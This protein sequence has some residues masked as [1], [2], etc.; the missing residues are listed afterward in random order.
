MKKINLSFKIISILFILGI[1]S[2]I[3]PCSSDNNSYANFSFSY[4]GNY[5]DFKIEVDGQDMNK[6]E[7]R[8]WLKDN[9]L[10]DRGLILDGK[11]WDIQK[12]LY[13][14]YG[15]DR[16]Y[17]L[18]NALENLNILLNG[19]NIS[20]NNPV[21]DL[22]N[23]D[24]L[25]P[26]RDIF[27]KLGGDTNSNDETRVLFGRIG[28][29]NTA[30]MADTN[31]IWVNDKKSTLTNK[32]KLIDGKM[33]IPSS[34]LTDIFG[35]EVLWDK[36]KKLI[37]IASD[38]GIDLDK[39]I[40]I[41]SSSNGENKEDYIKIEISDNNKIKISGNA[42]SKF[43]YMMLTIQ[44]SNKREIVDKV[45]TING[46]NYTFTCSTGKFKDGSYKINTFISP[47]RY[48]TY[49]SYYYDIPVQCEGGELFFPMS[50]VYKN[51]YVYRLKN[52]S[53]NP[54]LLHNVNEY[55]KLDLSDNKNTHEDDKKVIVNLA[56]KIARGAKT[57][58]EKLLKINDWVAENIYYDWDSYLKGEY[59]RT[60]AI[61]T[62]KTKKSVCQGYA[63]L[64]NALCRA[65]GIP[66][67][68]VSGYA[69]GVSAKDKSWD[70]VDHTQSNHAWNEVFVDSRWIILD[71]TWNSRNKY[72]NGQ[73]HKGDIRHN[74]F[75]PTL[76][77]FSYDHKYLD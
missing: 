73:F 74:Y 27:N 62:L 70:K 64:T 46:N 12:F 19:H 16:L 32:S 2:F 13:D 75:D 39:K 53:F 40:K 38:S 47:V 67:K 65:S 15:E 33:Y 66:C 6:E 52:F 17:K 42:N 59:G 20:L 31:E 50:P 29:T 1:I 30:V 51:N 45:F 10:F 54:K 61:G 63:E 7:F 43:K 68:V 28:Q 5:E 60:D 56:N 25:L 8:L 37:S 49:N 11:K 34:F 41:Y 22:Y 55:L 35:Y 36:N 21:Y 71:T 24:V 57:D 76:E 26:M 23:G 69:L 14:V 44:N 4:I 72:Q 9:S 3:F 48:G 18:D 58:Y 77:V